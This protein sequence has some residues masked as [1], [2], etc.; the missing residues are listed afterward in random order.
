MNARL[1]TLAALVATLPSARALAQPAPPPSGLAVGDWTFRPSIE[2]RTRGE[3]ARDPLDNALAPE[4]EWFVHER[5]RVGVGAERGALSASIQVQDA[6]VWGDPSP[7]AID[8]TPNAPSTSL[9]LAFVE[10]HTSEP[11]PSFLRL[12]RQEIAWGDGRL[13]GTSDWSPRPRALD[14][15]RG[16]WSAGAFDV[17]ALA[18]ILSPPGALPSDLS[19]ANPGGEGIGAELYGVDATVHL[20]PLL[21][22]EATG[23]ARI[24]RMPVS[25]PLVPSDLVVGSLR[26]FGDWMA[27][28]YAVEG[29]Y[30]AGRVA[31][32][33]DTRDLRAY[34]ATARVDW[35]TTW[36]LRPKLGLSGSYASGDDGGGTG[37]LHT[38]DPVLPDV[39]SGLGQIGLF[40]WSN[41]I[42]ASARVAVAPSDEWTAVVAYHRVMLANP[43]GTWTSASLTPIGRSA[44]NAD[45]ALGD[46]LD[47]SLWWTPWTELR[48]GAGYGAFFTGNGARAILAVAGRGEPKVEHAAYVQVALA[49]P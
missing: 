6:R 1:A 26:A 28:S 2:L 34:A 19:R 47:A 16:R 38:F 48:L 49:A 29:A 33:G 31:V 32:V 39:Q 12:G 42:D 3:Y 44:D 13:L 35:Q 46:E 9:H 43:R 22:L 17:E 40:A 36:P 14:A 37:T 24:V 10:A 25:P 7:S 20:A 23:L 21:A 41:L 8:R 45:R 4:N 5:A 18:A 27:L 30:E 11:H 15:I